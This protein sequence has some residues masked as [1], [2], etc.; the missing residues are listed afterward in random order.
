MR[1]REAPKGGRTLG[2]SLGCSR[3][4]I[5]TVVVLLG[6]MACRGT[7]QGTGG[8]AGRDRATPA[9]SARTSGAADGGA[10]AADNKNPAESGKR[11]RSR[12][13]QRLQVKV[14]AVYPH[15]PGAFTQGLV[16]DGGVLYEG[17]GLYG[18]SSLRRVEPMSGEVLARRA[19]DP[20]L[21]GEGLARV[22]DRL[23]QLT[24]KAGIV[25]V[26][27]L[28]SLELIDEYGF[29]GQGWGLAYD[30]TRLLMSDGSHRLTVR[31]LAD[32]RWRATIEVTQDGRPVD[33]LN[34]LEFAEGALYANVWGEER[35]V[36]VDPD[37]GEVDAVIDASGLL[38]PDERARVDVLN[39]IAYDP[40]SKTFWLTGKFWP[41]M[42]QVVFEGDSEDA[43]MAVE[44]TKAAEAA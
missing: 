28:A 43:A 22:D 24:W 16:W 3:A 17:T 25:L 21:F 41:K 27:D 20:N 44:V 30:G 14:Q 13:V 8:G 7:G 26:Y 15:D 40:V 5:A 1:Y 18:K 39:G 32:F 35:I 12:T 11:T 31:D 42:F 9:T 36:R 34:E 4:G 23:Y 29:N 37:T 6:L 10:S 2:S 33:Q 38:S 19:V